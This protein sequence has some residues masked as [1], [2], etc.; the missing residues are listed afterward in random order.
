MKLVNYVQLPKIRKE[1]TKKGV[2]MKEIEEKAEA[3]INFN[4]KKQCF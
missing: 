2:K 1:L 3:K 4:K